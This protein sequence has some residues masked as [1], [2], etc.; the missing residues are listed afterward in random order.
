MPDLDALAP[1]YRRARDHWKDAP[2]LSCCHD[3]LIKCFDG[4]AHGLVEHIK[5]FIEVVCVTILGE[6]GEPMPS[7]TPTTTELLVAALRPLGLQNTR[8]ASKLDK[9]LSGFNRLADALSEMRNDHGVVAHGKD[10]FLDGVATDHARAFL[11]AGDAVLSVLLNGMEGKE[12]NLIVTREPC[13]RFPHLN[14]RIDHAVGVEARVDEDGDRP[15]LVFA[16]ATGPMS[17]AIEIRVEPSRLLYGIDR[18]AYIEVLKTIGEVSRQIEEDEQR[19]IEAARA[20]DLQL[21]SAP[22]SRPVTEVVPVYGGRL[23]ALRLGVEGFLN[24]EGWQAPKAPPEEKK[25]VD[26][27]LATAD[28][29]IGLDWK[30][31]DGLQARLKVALRRVLVRFGSDPEKARRMAERLVAWLRIQVAD[32][33]EMPR[34]IN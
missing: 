16:V 22:A 12:P 9:V 1:N 31:R 15:V 7:A 34:R 30:Q 3:A 6:F 2:T 14:G 20:K 11:H 17:E 18:S 13:E 8:G 27:L 5:S 29:N 23:A 19:E 24:A 28:Q 33:G 25:L 32:A 26:S 4:D 10:A 21:A